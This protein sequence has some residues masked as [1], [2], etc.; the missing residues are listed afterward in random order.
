MKMKCAARI[1]T[2][3]ADPSDDPDTRLSTELVN[4]CHEPYPNRR[5]KSAVRSSRKIGPAMWMFRPVV[6]LKREQ[7]FSRKVFPTL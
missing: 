7:N 1:V 5:T 6:V 4:G 3:A 2:N